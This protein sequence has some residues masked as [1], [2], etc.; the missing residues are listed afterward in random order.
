MKGMAHFPALFGLVASLLMGW[1]LPAATAEERPAG[2]E[3]GKRVVD[4]TQ[5]TLIIL[6][7]LSPQSDIQEA[8]LEGI[9]GM[10]EKDREMIMD[11]MKRG[12]ST[13]RVLVRDAKTKEEVPGAKVKVTPVGP[14]PMAM[15]MP[16][17]DL[18]GKPFAGHLVCHTFR[19]GRY[20]VKVKVERPE[21]PK[22]LTATFEFDNRK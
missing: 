4:G 8:L 3:L 1:T 6:P 20:E 2:V 12:T 11:M 17:V 19:K 16:M 10:E 22:A 7:C 21:T 18:R 9:K 5:I 15:E 14:E 13:L